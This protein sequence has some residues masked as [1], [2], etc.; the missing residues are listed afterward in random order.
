MGFIPPEAALD[1]TTVSCS[2]NQDVCSLGV[3][4]LQMITI[5]QLKADHM[6]MNVV[7]LLFWDMPLSDFG[8]RVENYRP[9]FS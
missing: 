6:F 4:S 9:A 1:T 7:M 5:E 3:L 8:G 2:P